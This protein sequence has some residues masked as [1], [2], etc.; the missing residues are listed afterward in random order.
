MT[1][2]QIEALG[3]KYDESGRIYEI[4]IRPKTT[5]GYNKEKAE[6]FK[7]PKDLISH[8]MINRR[9][10]GIKDGRQQKV[11]EFKKLLEDEY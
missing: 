2:K 10:R 5:F 8:L 3:F 4:R 11:N 6:S 1:K 7:T 9:D